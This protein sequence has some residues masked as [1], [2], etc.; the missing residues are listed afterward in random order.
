MIQLDL[1]CG[2]GEWLLRALATHP[3]LRAEGV[4]VSENALEQARLLRAA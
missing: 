3:E 4:D 2:G 1:G